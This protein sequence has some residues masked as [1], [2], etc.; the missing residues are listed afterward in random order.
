MNYRKLF[1]MIIINSLSLAG[2]SYVKQEDILYKQKHAERVL[3]NRP[4]L[5]LPPEC[6]QERSE[7][8]MIEADPELLEQ[9]S[10]SLLPPDLTQEV[11]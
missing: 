11:R 6:T 3:E 8:Y 9:P 7:R 1:W 5:S 10:P 4:D 2:C